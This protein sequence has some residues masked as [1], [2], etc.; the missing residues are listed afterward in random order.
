MLITISLLILM[1]GCIAEPYPKWTEIKRQ[2]KIK[3]Y[4]EQSPQLSNH[5][6]NC[7][8][9]R[10]ITIGMKDREVLLSC[11]NPTKSSRS[12]GIWGNH[13]QW[14][15]GSCSRWGCSGITFL[16]FENGILT[17]WHKVD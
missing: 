15:Y 10:Q 8:L 16:Y 9:N 7:I 1:I 12:I 5:I 13:Q 2:E 17:S 4:F 14:Q 11:G 6:K 3:M